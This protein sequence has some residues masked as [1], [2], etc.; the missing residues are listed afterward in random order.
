MCQ[1]PYPG[2]VSGADAV[3]DPTVEEIWI[4]ERLTRGFGINGTHDGGRGLA[5][6]DNPSGVK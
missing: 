1:A 2:P 6:Q 5:L 4:N 3:D